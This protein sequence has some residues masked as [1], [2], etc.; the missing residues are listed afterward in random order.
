MKT[1]HD[2]S[3]TTSGNAETNPSRYVK[4]LLQVFMA[5]IMLS[6]SCRADAQ[7]VQVNLQL[8]PPGSLDPE[9][10]TELISFNNTGTAPLYVQMHATIEEEEKGL[11]FNGLSG[12]FELPAGFSVPDYTDYE[13]VEV[14]YSDPDLE[15]YVIQTNNMPGGDY[16]ICIR[17]I[18]AEV[19][20]EVG[21]N[22]IP[23]S[24]FH[25]S[26]P[27]LVYP[28]D[29]SSVQEP[30]PVFT[31]LPITP[32]PPVEVFYAIR[33][34][35]VFAGQLPY[36]AIQSNPSF[37]EDHEVMANIYPY[38]LAAAPMEE[39]RQYAWQVQALMAD[40]FP[41]GENEGYSEVQVFQYSTAIVD[42]EMLTWI[43]PQDGDVINQPHP[44]FRWSDPAFVDGLPHSGYYYSLQITRLEEEYLIE[45]DDEAILTEQVFFTDITSPSFIYPSY[46][47]PLIP[48]NYSVQVSRIQHEGYVPGVVTIID[49]AEYEYAVTFPG[50][51]L[52][53]TDAA[54][55]AS[56]PEVLFSFTE[57]TLEACCDTIAVMNKIWG[58]IDAIKDDLCVDKN[59]LMDQLLGALD[60]YM[61]KQWTANE[62]KGA[63]DAAGEFEDNLQAF[64]D[65]A[66]QGMQSEIDRLNDLR[67]ECNTRWRQDFLNRY[68]YNSSVGGSET[69]KRRRYDRTVRAVQRRFD[70]TLNYQIN[71]LQRHMDRTADRYDNLLNRLND[72]IAGKRAEHDQAQQEADDAMNRV[73]ELFNQIKDNLCGIEGAWD[74]LFAFMQDNF[75]CITKCA[76]EQVPVPPEFA[77]MEDCLKDLFNRLLDWKANIRDPGDQ[78][79]LKDDANQVFD[80]DAAMEDLQELNDLAEELAQAAADFNA[81]SRYVQVVD[82][83][84]GI[85]HTYGSGARSMGHVGVPRH[86]SGMRYGVPGSTQTF[87]YK[88]TGAY[89]PSRRERR[90]ARRERFAFMREQH[91]RMRRMNRLAWRLRIGPTKNRF[92]DPAALE[93][94]GKAAAVAHHETTADALDQLVDNMLDQLRQCYDVAKHHRQRMR[95]NDFMTEC[96]AYREALRELDKKYADHAE[97][98]A[99]EEARLRARLA[100]LERQLNNLKSRQSSAESAV[101]SLERMIDD[102]KN[103]ISELQQEKVHSDIEGLKSEI[104]AE[105]RQKLAELE[106]KLSE[107]KASLAK[108]NQ[109]IDDIERLRDRIRDAMDDFGDI[110]PPAPIG[111]TEEAN[112]AAE[113]V[114]EERRRMEEI[115]EAIGEMIEEAG[116]GMVETEGALDDAQGGAGGGLSEG[117]RLDLDLEGYLDYLRRLSEAIEE[118][119]LRKRQTDC[120]RLLDEHRALNQKEPGVLEKIWDALS[121]IWSSREELDAIPEGVFDDLDE[122]RGY[123]D[124]VENVRMRI[125]QALILIKGMN[126]DDPEARAKA[127]GEVMNIARELGGR[128]PGFGDMIAFY[129]GAYNESIAAIGKIADTIRDSVKP[130]VDGYSVH[131]DLDSWHGQ[132]LDDILNNEWDAFLQT[133]A[134][135]IVEIR[136]RDETELSIMKDYFRDKAASE[137]MECCFKE[138]MK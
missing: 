66:M 106:K 30:S 90:E 130:L 7:Q 67:D 95:F 12:I 124:E 51:G 56:S 91:E 78:R 2:L 131:C 138:L 121:S 46:A 84:C 104:L 10:L 43:S 17:L 101:D 34:V 57:A 97:K 33:L 83:A 93:A 132:S 64:K 119:E 105:L 87:A 29:G 63:L 102:I 100:K 62:L 36:E 128:V 108:A 118:R 65:Q 80:A 134:G 61:D 136:L 98:T 48:G 16:V 4:R 23:H 32:M 89:S 24:V 123:L 37:F 99:E 92:A 20:E 74:E 52:P 11:V 55:T 53:V 86:N 58:D 31:W 15:A 110:T 135:K 73:N 8:P 21:Y 28:P 44:L 113:A 42:E 77:E 35:E 115:S 49:P 26:A 82:N 38:P 88:T 18:D 41:V 126:T 45:E 137:I 112:D 75:C 94:H 81:Q 40:G 125:R 111:S 127:F 114:E 117:G 39:G 59:D 6:A 13:P 54:I 71:D 27:Q 120:L 133:D 79:A 14:E 19:G 3:Q 47:Q 9:Q 25:P 103:K 122:F 96:V 22:C 60:D 109:L 129:A 68:V 5:I 107:A 1:P 72:Y 50:E 69:A 85:L 76:E 116:K 70:R